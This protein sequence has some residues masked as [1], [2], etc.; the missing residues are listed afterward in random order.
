MENQEDKMSLR[1]IL[2][3]I[4][5]FLG[6]IVTLGGLVYLLRGRREDQAAI[7][8]DDILEGVVTK[9]DAEIQDIK[10][11][12]KEIEDAPGDMTDEEVADYFKHKNSK[13]RIT[14]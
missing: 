14:Q 13:P 2:N 12:I 5:A 4:L 3:Y 6:F 9:V 7:E 11:D 8:K 10:E 1:T